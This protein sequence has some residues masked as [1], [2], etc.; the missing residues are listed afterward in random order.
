MVSSAK[1][2]FDST[3]LHNVIKI[4][5]QEKNETSFFT[6]LASYIG[7]G[8]ANISGGIKHVFLIWD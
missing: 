1:N 4:S 7:V 6:F 3:S 5:A 2:C 8:F